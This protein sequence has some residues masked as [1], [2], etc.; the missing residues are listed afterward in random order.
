VCSSD[1]ARTLRFVDWV[2]R[3]KFIA[4]R[5]PINFDLWAYLKPMY[6]AVPEDLAGYDDTTM[7]SSQG[8]ATIRV[9]LIPPWAGARYAPI[10]FGYFL[11]TQD[12]TYDMSDR[13]LRLVQSDRAVHA[14]MGRDLPGD[15]TR[16]QQS[17]DEGAMS[18]RRLAGSVIFFLY[19]EGR[20]S[21]ESKPLDILIFDEVQEMAAADVQKADQ[22]IKASDLKAKFRVSTA[23]FE[24]EDIHAHFLRSDQREWHT[25]C[26]CPD[27]IVLSAPEYWH[28]QK[29]VTCVGWGNGST[30]GVPRE[31]FWL[32]PKCGTNLGP[33]GRT[34][35]VQQG[36]Y[37]SH[38][39]G[40]APRV[41][42]QF[43]QMLSPKVRA[44]E[45]IDEWANRASTQGFYN[46]VLGRPFTDPDV[47]PITDAVLQEAEAKGVAQGLQW[48][49]PGR[50]EVDGIF[51]GVDH[52][53]LL[54]VVV[55][56]G[57]SVATGRIRLLWLGWIA[58][59]DPFRETA[60]L[61]RAYRVRY[62]ALEEL[63]NGT[64]AFNFAK[65]FDGRVFVVTRYQPLPSEP[66][67]WDDR[68]LEK[69]SVRRTADEARVRWTVGVDQHRMMSWSLARFT[70][71]E[72]EMPDSRGLMVRM[73]LEPG[74]PERDVALCREVYWRHLKSV[75]LMTEL[76][77]Q[78]EDELRQPRRFVQ[79]LGTD[80]PHF[81]YANMLCDV[82]IIRAYGRTRFLA[83]GFEV[84]AMPKKTEPTPST[85]GEQLQ[86][87]QPTTPVPIAATLDGPT[88][89]SADAVTCGTCANSVERAGRL[90]C[91][92]RSFYVTPKLDACPQ[93]IAKADEDLDG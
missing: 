64:P 53:T 68:A 67:I 93:Y 43:G 23:N 24:G 15:D 35:R 60:E 61:M 10:Q 57:V 3:R 87:A 70:N 78:H 25:T 77:K 92:P 62:A 6:D 41:G 55:I 72:V 28:P 54:N 56:K 17:I 39:P 30:P 52:M 8:G 22:R 7:K 26:R 19:T 14:L 80:D 76:P 5:E 34:L 4:D 90:W 79:K 16:R 81:A 47:V 74:Q 42:W 33:G 13:F 21:T 48:G 71:G 46:R 40:N 27:G 44:R 37:I 31:P 51:M 63:P 11:P 45:I 85:Y 2:L 89:A 65:H 49:K 20:I 82:A 50:D 86:V 38:A 12:G 75:A 29:G 88:V 32:C 18:V 84:G 1:L 9:L 73:R 59:G 36:R 69:V 58:Q 83:T 91:Q 66:V